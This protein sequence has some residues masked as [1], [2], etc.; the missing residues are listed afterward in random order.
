MS[1]HLPPEMIGLM[2][3]TFAAVV[4]FIMLVLL[5]YRLLSVLWR[6]PAWMDRIEKHARHLEKY[7]EAM[8]A[9]V[10]TECQHRQ[11]EREDEQARRR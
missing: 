5:C 10:T 11:K 1:D 3:F 4:I 7:S 2:I 9:W 8:N 6:M